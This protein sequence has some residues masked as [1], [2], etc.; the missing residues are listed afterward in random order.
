MIF[1]RSSEAQ[2][3]SRGVTLSILVVKTSKRS[4]DTILIGANIQKFV[5]FDEK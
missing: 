2:V 1:V 5:K 4:F 3:A